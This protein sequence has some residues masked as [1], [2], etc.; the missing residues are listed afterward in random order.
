MVT[1][2][3]LL[4]LHDARLSLPAALDAD[5][6]DGR[7]NWY[8]VHAVLDDPS[9]EVGVDADEE[10]RQARVASICF[11]DS[12]SCCGS[13]GL[14]M[15]PCAP[16]SVAS[17]ADCSSMLDSWYEID[18]PISGSAGERY[19]FEMVPVEPADQLTRSEGQNQFSLR[20][21]TN[22]SFTPC[23]SAAGSNG[24]RGSRMNTK[25]MTS[26]MIGKHAAIPKARRSSR[27]SAR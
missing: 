6:P 20:I 15:K 18:E 26:E 8:I 1:A 17:P 11:A 27:V 2:D 5:I 19:Y 14:P 25:T 22:G 24:R 13:K 23:A 9:L 16:R 7:S 4:T 3:Y 12:I 21:E 10:G